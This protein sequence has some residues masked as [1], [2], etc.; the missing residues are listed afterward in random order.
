M[1]EQ[2]YVVTRSIITNINDKSPKREGIH[3]PLLV[4]T[5]LRF[6]CTL[7]CMNYKQNISVSLKI[8]FQ[9]LLL[10]S[11]LTFFYSPST[12]HLLTIFTFLFDEI[13]LWQEMMNDTQRNCSVKYF[14]KDHVFGIV[15]VK[16]YK[17]QIQILH[18]LEGQTMAMN[19]KRE[20]PLVIAL[21][22]NSPCEKLILGCFSE[23]SSES[24]SRSH[25]F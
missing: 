8:I 6:P 19:T 21:F 24:K 1:F 17:P 22:M 20:T 16:R 2:I 9:C 13:S 3:A 4:F 11:K 14:W 18:M 15:Y 23:K 12:F 5:K 7:W 10:A 25:L